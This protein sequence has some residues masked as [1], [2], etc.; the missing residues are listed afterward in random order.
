MRRG[1][2]ADVVVANLVRSGRKQP[3]RFRCGS[4]RLPPSPSPIDGLFPRPA[5][6]IAL[7][8]AAEH[9]RNGWHVRFPAWP[10]RT[11]TAARQRLSG[12]G[13]QIPAADLFRADRPGCDGHHAGQRDQA[14]P[15]GARLPAHRCPRGRQDLDRT[16]DRQGA[17]LHRPGW[18]GR[19]DDRSVRDL[20]AV[21]RDRRGAPYRRDRDG[22]RV[23]HRR[24]R[25]PRDHRGVALFGGFGALQD[26]HHRRSPHAVEE[27][28][29]TRCSRR[30][31]SR[32]RM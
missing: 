26:L 31:R 29:S 5:A 7:D 20:R 22:R 13:A 18:A 11:P 3:Q 4:F 16:A 19:A 23:A 32:R 8:A 28:R 15:A 12:A 10:R 6:C 21:P 27:P 24:G 25:C 17:Q 14:R 9:A 1:S 2:R 30:W